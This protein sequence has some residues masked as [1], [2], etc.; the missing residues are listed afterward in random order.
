MDEGKDNEEM[1]GSMRSELEAIEEYLNMICHCGHV[2]K[3]IG[4]LEE[5]GEVITGVAEDLRNKEGATDRIVDRIAN[6]EVKLDPWAPYLNNGVTPYKR[7]K[8]REANVPI[9]AFGEKVF[10]HITKQTAIEINKAD[11]RWNGGVYLGN[12]WMSGEYVIGTPHGVVKTNSRRRLPQDE[13]WDSKAIRDIEG[14][15]WKPVPNRSGKR[16]LAHTQGQHTRN[17]SVTSLKVRPHQQ[18]RN[19]VRVKHRL[20]MQW[21]L[22]SV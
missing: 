15:P 4:D 3:L 22:E 12:L 6:I 8:G 14:I 5:L 20:V 21:E 13:C 11:S 16:M 2:G 9:A 1:I 7:V 19:K 10:Y 17:I 18:L